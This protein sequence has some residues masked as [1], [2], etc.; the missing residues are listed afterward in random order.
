[1]KGCHFKYL[2]PTPNSLGYMALQILSKSGKS[3]LARID[4]R[5]GMHMR[6]DAAWKA[7]PL[8]AKAPRGFAITFPNY[9]NL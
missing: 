1:M 9:G 7:K 4:D 8:G 2:L 3:R 6:G 5:E